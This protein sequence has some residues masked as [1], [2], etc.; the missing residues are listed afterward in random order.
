[1][2]ELNLANDLDSKVTAKSYCPDLPTPA[3]RAR[4]P[5]YSTQPNQYWPLQSHVIEL[6]ILTIWRLWKN[7]PFVNRL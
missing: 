2:A 6:V 7:W 1:M 5:D 3:D 4:R